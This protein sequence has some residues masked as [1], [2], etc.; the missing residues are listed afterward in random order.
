MADSTFGQGG[1]YRKQGGDMVVPS[2]ASIT[3][4]TGGT[5]LPNSGT[6]ASTIADSA[7]LTEGGGAIG[8]TNDGD[9][10]ALVDPAGDSGASVIAGI[11]E[12]ATK[13][14]ELSTKL[15]AVLLALENVGILADS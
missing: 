7:A 8:G 6:Q 14:N 4:E 10:T 13:C 15:N 3:I 12:N 2:G 9:L 11:R 5:L 1:V